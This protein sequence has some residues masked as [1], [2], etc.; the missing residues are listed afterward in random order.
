MKTNISLTVI[1]KQ[2]LTGLASA[3]APVSLPGMELVNQYIM[4][5][6]SLTQTNELLVLQGHKSQLTSIQEKCR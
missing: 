3:T 5:Y 2:S 1:P 6:L 4:G